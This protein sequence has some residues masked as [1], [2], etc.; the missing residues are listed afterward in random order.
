MKKNNIKI[1]ICGLRRIEDIECINKFKPE[2]M[3]YIFAK[4]KRYINPEDAS[5]FSKKISG[6]IKKVGVFVNEEIE[7]ILRIVEITNVDIVQLHGDENLE[8]IEK[9]YNKLNTLYIFMKKD[10]EIWK[11]I[12]ITD[13]EDI[14]LSREFFYTK[15]ISK[16]LLDSYHKD[17]YGGM[18]ISFDWNILKD[19][20]PKDYILAGGLNCDNIERALS[21]S[22]PDILDVSSGV[23]TDGYKDCNKIKT[24]IEKVRNIK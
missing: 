24:F 22:N 13:K 12:R 10:V 1:K 11:A 2:Y 16:I 7:E 19:D 3:G 20:I 9:L 15:Y 23:E 6:D 17:E 14:D 4:S 5:L 18:G 8:Y 21:I